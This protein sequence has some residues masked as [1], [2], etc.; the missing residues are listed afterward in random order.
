[1]STLHDQFYPFRFLRTIEAQVALKQRRKFRF[2]PTYGIIEIAHCFTKCWVYALTWSYRNPDNCL[3]GYHYC[4]R[5]VSFLSR[6]PFTLH[7]TINFLYDVNFWI[8]WRGERDS[9]LK[10]VC[11]QVLKYCLLLISSASQSLRS[12]DHHSK[13]QDTAVCVKLGEKRILIKIYLASPNYLR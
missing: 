2:Y 10:K 1:M 7:K 8:D 12:N 4:D 13:A 9:D 5:D 11:R 6:S 3:Q